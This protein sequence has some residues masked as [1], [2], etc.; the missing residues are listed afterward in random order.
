MTFGAVGRAERSPAY[1]LDGGSHLLLV[2]AER[3][4]SHLAS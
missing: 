2:A 4:E 1:R 3:S